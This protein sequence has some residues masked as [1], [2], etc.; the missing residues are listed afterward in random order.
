MIASIPS[1]VLLGVD[2]RPVSVEVH[3][4]NGLTGFTIVRLPDAIRESRDRL[5]A[6]K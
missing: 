4:S 1:A 6:E 3:V 2:G 5:R